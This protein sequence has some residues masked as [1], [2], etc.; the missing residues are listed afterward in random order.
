VSAAAYVRS[1]FEREMGV[2]LNNAK[3]GS[4][5]DEA[6][7]ELTREAANLYAR[8]V[9]RELI[10]NAY[11]GA[12]TAASPKILLR[13][14]LSDGPHGT[15][16][17]ANNGQG[18]SLENVDAISNPAMSN[19]TPGNFIGH[20]GLGFRSVE[21]LS[22]KVEIL[23]KADHA[24]T[25]FDGFCFRFASSEDERTWVERSAEPGLADAIVGKV[26]RL[27]LPFPIDN[28]DP[29]AD[30]IA[31]EG[32]STLI[33]L[34]LRDAVAT[35]RAI[36]EMRLL[37]DEVAP[38]TL[39]LDRLESLLLETIYADGRSEPKELH[40]EGK[41]P[42]KSPFGRSLTIEEVTVDRYRYLV[43]RMEVDDPAFR[44]SVDRAVAE[45]F[46]VERW[47]HWKGAPIVSVAL[48]LSQDA[49]A[50]NF[51]AFLPMDTAAPFNGCLDA[52]FHPDANRRGLDLDNPLNGLLLDSVA[53]L[54]LAMAR[55]IAAA[56]TSS[57][58]MSCAA[59]DAL[60]WTSEPKRLLDACE[61]A[62]VVDGDI[63]LPTIRSRDGESRW[64]PLSE[65]YD[66]TDADHRIISGSWIVR[67]C[68]VPM[69]RRGLGPKRNDALR[70]FIDQTE[71]HLDPDGSVA[72][73][74]APRLAA[75]L[76]SRRRK[77][78][79]QDWENFYL[80]LA[81]LRTALPYLRGK[82]IFR[83]EDGSLGAANS[84][85]T[86]GERELYI[87]ADPENATR[88]RKRLA[89]TTLFPPKSVAKRMLFADPLLSWPA[90]VTSV[91]VTAGLATEFSL[92]RVIAGMG[93][94]LGKR[95]TRQTAIAAIS[96]AFSAWK[97]HKSNEV[98]RALLAANL[99]IP[100][101]GGRLRAAGTA[102]FGAGWRD[103]MGDTL[104][105]LCDEIGS[106]TRPT[107]TLCDSLLAP[108]DEWPLR[109]RGPAT[110]WVQFLRLL[111]VRD[112]LTAVLYPTVSQYVGE[113]GG[114]RGGYGGPLPIE[115]RL[116][117]TWRAAVT[118]VQRGFGYQ[119]GYYSTGDTMFALPL[120][121]EHAKMND[122]AK[123]AYAR[124]IV[125]GIPD[126][127]P[128]YFATILSK[129]AGMSD[130]VSWPSPLL[131]FLMEAEWL[132][133]TFANELHWRR[134]RECWFVPR[135]ETLPHFLPRLERPIRES[136]DA[137]AASRE[138]FS[139]RL[140]LRLWNER[141]S[142]L[143]RLQELGAVLERGIA[144]HEYDSFRSEC[145]QAWSDWNA[146][147]PS[148]PLPEGMVLAVQSS[149]RL[150]PHR[151]DKA[152]P[153]TIFVSGGNDPTL[154]NLLM[155]LGHRLLSVPADTAK[156]VAE[157]LA[158]RGV[159]EIRLVDNVQPSIIVDGEELDLVADRPRLVEGD[160]DWLAEIA[161]LALEFHNS[162][163]NRSTARSRRALFEDFRRLRI[164]HARDI[165]VE[166]DGRR[167][168][169]PDMLAGVLPVPHKERP[170]IVMQSS[171]DGLDWTAIDRL[172]RG[173]A[174]ALS[175]AWLLTDF[176]MV[177]L[178]ISAGQPKISGQLARPDDEAIATAF[179]QPVARI[180]EIQR[181]LRSG[182]R[183]I[184]DWLLPIVGVTLGADAANQ[185]LDRE[186]S[187]VED[188]EIVA[189]IV[190]AGG[191]ADIARALV[192]ACRDAE[193]LD[194]LRR[195]LDIPLR[196][197]NLASLALGPRFP[198][199]RFDAAL[200]RAFDD[201][202][203]EQR[204]SLARRVRDA[205]AAARLAEVKLDQY[206]AAL[207]LDWVTFDETWPDEFDELDDATIDARIDL[208][209]SRALPTPTTAKGD[210]ID[211]VRQRNRA[212]LSA[213]LEAI[214]RVGAAWASKASGRNLPSSWSAKP[215]A[216]VREAI[217]TGAFDFVA[218]ETASLPEALGYAGMWPA[219]MPKTTELAAL[220]LVEADLD[221]QRKEEE[222]R[223]QDDQR[224]SRSVK[225]GNTEIEGGSTGSLQAVVDVLQSGLASKAFQ[226]RSGPAILRPFPE[227]DERPPRTRTSTGTTKEPTFLTDPQRDLIGFA[228]E[229]A[230]YVHLKR[231]VRNFA[232]EHW[233]SSLGRRFLCIGIVPDR[234]YDFY[235]P[236][237]RGGLYYEVKAHSGDP[238]H[239]DLERSQVEAA[240]QYSDE[241]SGVWRIL[242]I[243]HVLDPNHITV[244]ELAN[245]FAEGNMRLFRSS[246]R[247]GVRLLID[248][249]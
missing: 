118:K 206:R 156:V 42:D 178:A 210:S 194:E 84:P 100:V 154:D 243:S 151:P 16:Y 120:Q 135:T 83:L 224:R 233:I 186:H 226:S 112:G 81:S 165:Q 229:Y 220:D 246:N 38:I 104:R 170:T 68:G 116:G 190:Q 139:T 138:A 60:A 202:I 128:R 236:R 141:E 25:T 102:R 50:G 161:V 69:L 197:F 235:V 231:T 96:W 131:A 117:N 114:L 90:A 10:Q 79:K 87:S 53:D 225:F 189:A 185:L 86:L 167:G 76:A 232:D 92:P 234:G 19:K 91:F 30:A 51:Y 7:R 101:V 241:K 183:R 211:E 249:Q 24:S 63:Q 248:R 26:H 11:D 32:F 31:R 119:S 113:W 39:F 95:P 126:M 203:D 15:I 191:D 175:R 17:V 109:E 123:Q 134:P 180:R 73:E 172:S 22:D 221:L 34:P 106:T 209:A 74:W 152:Q 223:R 98:E 14:D 41:G 212:T 146:L 245:P 215:E 166:V 160:R 177:F 200:R 192:V 97:S 46:P 88:R 230:A 48:P 56:D 47:R 188:D 187:L 142:A 125:K 144:E 43:G 239:V 164:I 174:L 115:A 82:E 5:R 28:V 247:Q 13:L 218:V 57:P 49:R 108:W 149:G 219:G 52:P 99:P 70:T 237:S 105:E 201:R 137:S 228:G 179:G 198:A 45:N 89:G 111:G 71:F 182:S 169:L 62:E 150:V 181:S 107:K 214:R 205:H 93:R 94:L 12:R 77:A 44:D 78:T 2:T 67:A 61:R 157:A 103:T 132:P 8:R 222:R 133:I 35:Q 227:G 199:L 85:E 9:L 55:T 1:I 173:L 147:D 23:S 64:A 155:A 143:A 145:R 195:S 129:T 130:T 168:P 27:Q 217:M 153:Q 244:H 136:I 207:T 58:T 121:S 176:R 159:D 59:V 122:R 4:K 171:S 242:Y 40:R 240:V 238:G 75:D 124:L 127:A 54:C 208:L 80:D 163:I 196:A 216:L 148:S 72:A 140:G 29:A 20:K 33:R 65:I 36:D 6:M 184:M 158:R 21:L 18:F 213:N 66:W 193:G 3:A 204:S 162:A 37:I 110:E